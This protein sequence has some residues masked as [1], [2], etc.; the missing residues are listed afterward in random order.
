MASFVTSGAKPAPPKLDSPSDPAWAQ[1]DG[2]ATAASNGVAP[3]RTVRKTAAAWACLVLSEDRQR[4]SS[5]GQIAT[6]AGWDP[7]ECGSVGEALR[8]I[9]RW[10]TQLSV[11]DLG[12][13]SNVQ[14]A[15]YMQFAERVASRDRLLLVCDEPLDET[16][17]QEGELRARQAGA[18]LYVPSPDL[19]NGFANLLGEARCIAEKI[20]GSTSAGING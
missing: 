13:M 19:A 20:T 6:D 15:S 3:T 12:T 9:Q 17:S 18:W 1:S 16:G 2:V 4:R 7:I 14:K 10:R 11:I 8:E 5:L